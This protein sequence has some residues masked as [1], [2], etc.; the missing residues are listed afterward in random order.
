MT[1]ILVLGTADWNQPIATNQHYV[2]RELAQEFSLIYTESMGLR[3][4]ELK[5]RDIRRMARRIGIGRSAG[6]TQSR[7]TPSGVEV[8]SP[9]VLPVHTGQLSRRIN[10]PRIH[11]L[12]QDWIEQPGPRLLWTYSP[13]TYGLERIA[14]ST[15]YHCVDLLGQ[16]DGISEA[17]ID[18]AERNLS[19]HATTAIGTSPVV[20][21]H[22]T[23]QGFDDVE[24]WPNVADTVIIEAAKPRDLARHPRRA[25]F[26]GNLSTT[27]VDF[28]LLAA[29]T[30]SGIDLHLAGPVAE[31]GGRAAAELDGVVSRGAT[32]HG[33]LNPTELAELY[34]SAQV[35]L[36]PYVLNAYTRGVSPL[37]TYEY[38]A[39]GLSVVSTAVPSVQELDDHI[40]VADTNCGFVAAV[41]RLTRTHSDDLAAERAALAARNSWTGRGQS[42]RDLARVH[43]A[44]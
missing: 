44:L 25:V 37:K 33:L 36:I 41:D 27:K 15:V 11:A 30:D 35:G 16:V 39:A 13:V 18:G 7:S 20:V 17:L 26:A 9:K 12:V 1:K 23:R 3:A 29:L 2:V 21:E 22:L 31:G 10:T 8:R 32:Y 5:M 40:I 4:P 34:W 43:L 14:T 19:R 42:A 28:E 24:F 6:Q 38:L